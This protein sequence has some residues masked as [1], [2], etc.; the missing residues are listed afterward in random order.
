[1]ADKVSIYKRDFMKVSK[2]SKKWVIKKT[3]YDVYLQH[4]L[5]KS[6]SR[7]A[8]AIKFANKLRTNKRRK[9]K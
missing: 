6:F 8:D 1:M 5:R 9:K 3:R 2:K 4:D 7:K